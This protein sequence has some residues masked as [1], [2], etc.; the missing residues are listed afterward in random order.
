MN[1]NNNDEI[2]ISN[3]KIKISKKKNNSS[4]KKK[5]SHKNLI[6]HSEYKSDQTDNSIYKEFDVGKYINVETN[7][8]LE[9]YSEFGFIA[10]TLI[11]YG[12]DFYLINEDSGKVYTIPYEYY[13]QNL[14]NKLMVS[15]INQILKDSVPFT[16]KNEPDLSLVV[17]KKKGK[18]IIFD[19]DFIKYKGSN[20][21]N[22]K[23]KSQYDKDS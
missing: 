5:K 11:K 15:P 1:S 16:D 20:I 12:S 10:C 8:I 6:N 7:N 21:M 18:H 23:N 14:D 4:P 17:G 13:N 19:P 22:Q 9:D 2:K 3:T